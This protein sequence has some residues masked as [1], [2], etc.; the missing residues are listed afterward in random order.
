M[1]F[2]CYALEN[3]YNL[4]KSFDSKIFEKKNKLNSKAFIH[5]LHT[6]WNKASPLQNVDGAVIL[7]N[8]FVFNYYWNYNQTI[9]TVLIYGNW[10]QICVHYL[11]I[12]HWSHNFLCFRR[13][14][15]AIIP[16]HHKCQ[17]DN[18]IVMFIVYI[19]I[20]II[21]LLLDNKENKID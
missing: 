21:T 2:D 10:L 3:I 12:E 1:R 20:S 8:S 11:V 4:R 9:V 15:S 13:Y 5:Q 17:S 6:N 7:F 14:K 19:I 16:W 18:N